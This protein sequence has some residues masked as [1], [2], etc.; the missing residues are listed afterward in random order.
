MIETDPD[1]LD[2]YR[3]QLKRAKA[4]DGWEISAHGNWTDA[5]ATGADH[6]VVVL[7]TDHRNKVATGIFIRR[8]L[9][10][11]PGAKIVLHTPDADKTRHDSIFA[12]VP[13][14]SRIEPLAATIRTVRSRPR[15]A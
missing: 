1:M 8:A 11:F 10:Y 7:G 3:A 6:D 4:L 12:S 14:Q 2:H 15:T 13:K 5:T 9:Q